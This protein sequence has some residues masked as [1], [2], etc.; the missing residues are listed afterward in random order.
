MSGFLSLLFL[1]VGL[2]VAFPLAL[3]YW[4]REGKRKLA[5]FWTIT[6]TVCATIGLG[7]GWVYYFYPP[8][9]VIQT[10]AAP[11]KPPIRPY[12]DYKYFK[13]AQPLEASKNIFIEDVIENSS[14]VEAL[15]TVGGGVFW[16]TNEVGDPRRSSHGSTKDD[17]WQD[18]F[19]ELNPRT[20]TSTLGPKRTVRGQLDVQVDLSIA[21]IEDLKEGRTKLYFMTK[22]EYRAG[23]DKNTAYPLDLC[24]VYNPKVQGG[25]A[26]CPD[27]LPFKYKEKITPTPSP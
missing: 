6:S 2:A 1:G 21:M 16:Y 5:I 26:Y 27:D 10:I 19:F 13:L 3:Y 22:G 15:V 18:R 11:D 9:A 24:R 12:V 7:A 4:P 23:T 8:P 17:P 25:F 14:D 20:T